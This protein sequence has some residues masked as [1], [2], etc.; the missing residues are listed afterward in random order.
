MAIYH[1]DRENKLHKDLNKTNLVLFFDSNNYPLKKNSVEESYQYYIFK[2]N[3]FEDLFIRNDCLEH[4]V[5]KSLCKKNK[6]SILI[7]NIFINAFKIL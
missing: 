3:R 2:N 7:S 5:Y 1:V 6:F 4:V